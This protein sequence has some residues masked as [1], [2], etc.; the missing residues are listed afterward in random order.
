MNMRALLLF[1]LVV[2]VSSS[3]FGQ[4]MLVSGT[5]LENHLNDPDVVI[6]HVG[7]QQD[8]DEGHIPGAR[9]VQLSDVSV[10]D[11]AGLRLQLPRTEVLREALGKVGV[12]DTSMVVIYHATPAIQSATRVWFTLDYLGMGNRAALLDGGISLWKKEGRA[13]SKEAVTG[14]A[15]G[16]TPRPEPAKV[17][18]AEWMRQHLDDPSVLRV[19]ARTPNFYAGAEKGLATRAGHIPG[20]INT[21]YSSFLDTD[22]RFRTR[23]ELRRLLH[24]GRAQPEPLRVT[25][26]H[27]GQQATVPYFVARYLGLDVRLFDGSFQEWSSREAFPIETSDGKTGDGAAH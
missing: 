23:E 7:A 14:G 20:A 4:G 24:V 3:A 17:V 21:P 12:T 16:P 26:C 19:D 18:S 15:G 2:A 13:V 10:T 22:G 6:L 8:Y 25:Y 27:I 1:A 5:W 9:L 11:E